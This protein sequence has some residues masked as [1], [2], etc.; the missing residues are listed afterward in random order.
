MIFRLSTLPLIATA[1]ALF[2]SGIN[3][4]KANAQNFPFETTYSTKV[5]LTELRDNIFKAELEGSS[6]DAPYGLT[7][8]SITNSYTRQNPVTNEFVFDPDPAKFNLSGLP[9][10]TLILSGDGK[11]KLFGELSG[12]TTID[13]EN[14]VGSGSSTLKIIGGEGIFNGA[15]GILNVIENDIVNPDGSI[16]PQFTTFGSFKVVKTVSEPK[17][18][19]TILGMG[20]IGAGLM[21]R[22][23][24]KKIGGQK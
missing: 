13:F 11:D 19:K 15:I 14:G 24:R 7:D 3:P 16:E 18:T 17:N 4:Q 8:F 2:S 20:I 6:S 5:T 10:A 12:S 23:R 9:K 21:L 1:V 22:Q